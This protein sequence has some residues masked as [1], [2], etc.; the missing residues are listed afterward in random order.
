MSLTHNRDFKFT[1]LL[2]YFAGNVW[3]LLLVFLIIPISGLL[4]SLDGNELAFA[5]SGALL[6]AFAV[7]SVYFNHIIKE[8]TELAK[9]HMRASHGRGESFQEILES[10]NPEITDEEMR[11]HCA[12]LMFADKEISKEALPKLNKIS[13][14]II[15]LE[16][17]AGF[18]GTIIWGF[19]DIPFVTV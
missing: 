18:V 6:V 17:F 3:F 1:P 12:I 15:K 9:L 4:L 5:R 16:F 11:K 19:G 2:K 10:I 8:Q 7:A 13:E 14:N